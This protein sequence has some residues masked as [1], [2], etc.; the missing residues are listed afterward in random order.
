MRAVPSKS[1]T[2]AQG[3]RIEADGSTHGRTRDRHHA[4]PARARARRAPPRTRRATRSAGER[5]LVDSAGAAGTCRAR[6]PSRARGAGRP[7]SASPSRAASG[8]RLEERDPPARPHRAAHLRERR[9]GV[10]EEVEEAVA[11]RAVERAARGRA[12]RARRRARAAGRRAPARA[13][14][15]GAA[16]HRGG[17]VEPDVPPRRVGARHLERA[18]ARADA[19]VEHAR[20]GDEL[21]HV[22][23]VAPPGLVVGEELVDRRRAPER[24]RRVGAAGLVAERG[25]SRRARDAGRGGAPSGRRG[26]R[27]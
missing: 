18:R 12:A 1:Q 17:E 9:G 15:G 11:G 24:E 8:A 25:S 13:W 23:A 5:R 26:P 16:E 4:V 10:G 3:A 2:M 20:P 6:A 22:A 7:R 19:E 21:R 14:R 27:R